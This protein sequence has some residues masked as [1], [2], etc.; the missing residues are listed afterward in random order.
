M[1][2]KKKRISPEERAKKFEPTYVFGY[3]SLLMADG[4][5]GRGMR[6]QYTNDDLHPCT[7]TGFERSM[8]AFFGGRNFYGLL[9]SPKTQINGVCFKIHDWYDYRSFLMSEGATSLY[10]DR[11]TYWPVRVTDRISGWDVPKGHRVMTLLCK[12]DRSQFGRVEHRY[13]WICDTGAQVWGK[14]FYQQFL[15][16]GGVP[17]AKK[18]RKMEKIAENHNMQIW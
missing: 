16:T 14:E 15:K 8:C 13:V 9:K 18:R 4:V 3:G 17:F 7:L 11:R 10:K 6:Y 12:E 5:N 1:K 2:K